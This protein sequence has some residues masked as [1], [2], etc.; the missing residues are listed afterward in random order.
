LGEHQLAQLFGSLHELIRRDPIYFVLLHT[1]CDMREESSD[2]E[3]HHCVEDV[4]MLETLSH[5][6]APG[7]AV[8]V[9]AGERITLFVGYARRVP[10]NGSAVEIA[11]R[12]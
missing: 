7:F 10:G 5:P 2:T 11:S 12:G 8:V 6:I 1:L 3:P 9:E 4:R